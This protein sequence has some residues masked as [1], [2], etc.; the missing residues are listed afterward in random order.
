MRVGPLTT[1]AT[2]SDELAASGT[3]LG[4]DESPERAP[5]RLVQAM[6]RSASASVFDILR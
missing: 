5:E 4:R 1:T 3:A 6:S 2:E